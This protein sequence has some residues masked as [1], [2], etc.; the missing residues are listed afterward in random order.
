[1]STSRRTT[2]CLAPYAG[3]LRRGR[4]SGSVYLIVLVLV[5]AK[6]YEDPAVGLGA[7]SRWPF[8]R[9]GRCRRSSPQMFFGTARFVAHVSYMKDFF[10]L[11]KLER[12]GGEE[13]GARDVLGPGAMSPAGASSPQPSKTISPRCRRRCLRR[14]LAAQGARDVRACRHPLRARDVFSTRVLPAPP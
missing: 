12:E 13:G 10:D 14:R 8:R 3:Q 9:R 6:I 11:E 4:V 7:H 2:L 5:A 1:M